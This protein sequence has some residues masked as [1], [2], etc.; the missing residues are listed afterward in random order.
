LRKTGISETFCSC[1]HIGRAV[2][3][4]SP[5]YRAADPSKAT[6]ILN[7]VG[8][9]CLAVS[10]LSINELSCVL[11][12]VQAL[13]RSGCSQYSMSADLRPCFLSGQSF[14]RPS[15]EKLLPDLRPNEQHVYTLVLDLNDTLV[16]S[17]WKV[18]D[19]GSRSHHNGRLLVMSSL[20]PCLRFTCFASAC[21]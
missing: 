12:L 21:P 14:S 9:L 8:F 4:G 3:G 6:T 17:D 7:I 20:I 19:T 16:H 2:P 15:S 10:K 5:K 1:G 11:L 13:R 18:G